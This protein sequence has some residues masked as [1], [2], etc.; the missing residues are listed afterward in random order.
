MAGVKG[1]VWRA[2]APIITLD[3]AL[4]RVGMLPLAFLYALEICFVQINNYYANH[5]AGALGGGLQIYLIFLLGW[6]IVCALLSLCWQRLVLGYSGDSEKYGSCFSPIWERTARRRVLIYLFRLITLFLIYQLLL[7]V[8]QILSQLFFQA[9]IQESWYIVVYGILTYLLA[10]LVIGVWGLALTAVATDASDS[11]IRNTIRSGE[12]IS[13]QCIWAHLMVFLSSM[14]IIMLICM[15]VALGAVG[16][17]DVTGAI[18]EAVKDSYYGVNWVHYSFNVPILHWQIEVSERLLSPLDPN[19]L[20]DMLSWADVIV[21]P[22]ALWWLVV[23]H[24]GVNALLFEACR[25][26]AQKLSAPQLSPTRV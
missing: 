13:R 25:G 22:L 16:V 20:E 6:I 24:S 21:G 7:V 9:F 15:L 26:D 12:G 8:L 17:M 11:R 5:T 10:F 19:L 14:G 23:A 1:I 4:L 3:D 2:L 18:P